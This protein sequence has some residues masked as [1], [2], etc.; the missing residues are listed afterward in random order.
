M[1]ISQPLNKIFP[2]GEPVNLRPFDPRGEQ[3][4]Q[5]LIDAILPTPLLALSKPVLPY[6]VDIDDS[7]LQVGALLLRRILIVNENLYD[8]FQEQLMTPKQGIQYLN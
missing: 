6:S 7:K 1:L 2:R 5:K 4:F 3:L 8:Y